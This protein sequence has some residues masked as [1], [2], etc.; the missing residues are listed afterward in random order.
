MKDGLIDDII[1]RA[2][3]PSTINKWKQLAAKELMAFA[4]TTN[5][6]KVKVSGY[7]LYIDTKTYRYSITLSG[8]KPNAGAVKGYSAP[9]GRYEPARPY[10][11][12]YD[13]SW[14]TLTKRRQTAPT[15]GVKPLNTEY[16]G[17]SGMPTR[18]FGLRK[19]GKVKAYGLYDD[20]TA[21]PIYSDKGFV[22]YITE[23]NINEMYRILE[24]SGYEALNNTFGG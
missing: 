24:E 13:G 23:I 18:F 5:P 22:D 3:N 4:K 17:E 1:S 19:G 15:E 16:Y 8:V 14:H 21:V 20:N 6:Y 11:A 2:N 12:F 7:Y 10:P 9:V